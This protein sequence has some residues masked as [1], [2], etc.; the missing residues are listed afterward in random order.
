MPAD[1]LRISFLLPVMNETYL[2]EQTVAG[3][4]KAA[5]DDAEEILIVTADRT[6]PEAMAVVDRLIAAYPGLIRHH[7]QKLP[8]LGGAMQEAFALARG[9][10]VMLMSSDMETDPA[11]IPKFILRMREGTWDIVAASRWI[12]GGG[13]AGYSTVKWLLN[14]GFQQVFRWLYWCRVTDLTYAYRLYK[15]DVLTG[16]RWE[17]MKHPFLLE[18][19]LKPLRLGA[20]LAEVP[21]L[22]RARTEG[23]SGN[24]LWETFKYLRIAA[25]VRF[26]PHKMI[27]EPQP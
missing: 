6:T 22:W 15:R 8:F 19:L 7:R 26:M 27:R 21:A 25:R 16:I 11:V 3:I 9:D 10:H 18:S 17:E 4:L 2:L 13:F 24:T 14:W 1:S 5:A 12:R 23:T 20:R